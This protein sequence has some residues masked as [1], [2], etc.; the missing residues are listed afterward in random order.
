M[1]ANGNR[2]F[3][4]CENKR[5]FR[6]SCNYPLKLRRWICIKRPRVY[7]IFTETRKSSHFNLIF[8]LKKTKTF[9]RSTSNLH[10]LEG[11]YKVDGIYKI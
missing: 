11:R 10:L 2:I 4:H 6:V 1:K 3:L 9:V 7:T 5:S 8:T